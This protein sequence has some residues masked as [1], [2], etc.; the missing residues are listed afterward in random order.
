M[1]ILIEYIQYTIYTISILW[2]IYFVHLPAC[3]TFSFLS[4]SF[5]LFPVL[6][7]SITKYPCPLSRG[8]TKQF[9]SV[10][11]ATQGVFQLLLEACTTFFLLQFPPFNPHFCLHTFFL[12]SKVILTTTI[13][14]C[15]VTYSPAFTLQSPISVRLHLLHNL[16][17]P[18]MCTFIHSYMSL[19]APPSF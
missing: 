3:P 1:Y 9:F 16:K 11:P 7:H 17:F 10:L 8:Y 6:P 19:N 4:C 12:I 2:Y 14:C 15:L 5:E 18:P 13:R